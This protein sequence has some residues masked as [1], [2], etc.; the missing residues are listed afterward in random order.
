MEKRVI[1]QKTEQRVKKQER[2]QKRMPLKTMVKAGAPKYTSDG[3]WLS[4]G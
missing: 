4:D 1:K 3:I 2:K